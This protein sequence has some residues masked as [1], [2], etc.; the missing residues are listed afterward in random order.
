MEDDVRFDQNFRQQWFKILERFK[1]LPDQYDFLYL[2]RK[3]NDGKYDEEIVVDQLFVRPRYSYWTIGYYI[4]RTG[5]EKL[6]KAN[7]TSRMIPVDEFL[8]IMYGAHENETLIQMFTNI[9]RLEALSL[10]H[11]IVSPTHY[12]GNPLYISDTEYS[13]E[14]SNKNVLPMEDPAELFDTDGNKIKP[15]IQPPPLSLPIKHFEL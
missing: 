12:V 3:L 9:E 13:D 10:R 11:L 5:I 6:L 8:P 14:I 4:T 2:G 1:S 15:S 7:P